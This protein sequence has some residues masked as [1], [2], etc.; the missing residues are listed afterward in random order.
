MTKVTSSR[1]YFIVG[2]V[3]FSLLVLTVG[4]ASAK[5]FTHAGIIVV[6]GEDYY[7]AGAPDIPGHFWVQAGLNQVVGKHY[8]SPGPGSPSQW[9][10]SDA[11]D[12]ALLFM[13]KGIIDTWDVD[14][15]AYYASRGY[16]HYHELVTFTDGEWEEHPT[17]VVWLKHTAVS[18]FNFDGGPMPGM[19]HEVSPGI[20]YEFMP[21]GFEPYDPYPPSP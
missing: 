9:W 8:N 12:G 15:A 7:M 20:D 10:S 1:K 3:V 14:K 19:A 16:V 5:G 18:H 13:V 2:L 6:D 17:K 4:F 21:N 11:P